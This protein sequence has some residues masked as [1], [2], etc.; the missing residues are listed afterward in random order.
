M[1]GLIQNVFNLLKGENVKF[2]R[3]ARFLEYNLFWKRGLN[4][5][6]IQQIFKNFRME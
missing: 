2:W 5:L 4:L 6:K 1:D 3:A